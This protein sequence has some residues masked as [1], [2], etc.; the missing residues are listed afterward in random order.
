LDEFE[1]R[2][3]GFLK[4]KG[5]NLT[6]SELIDVISFLDEKKVRMIVYQFTPNDWQFNISYYQNKK[7]VEEKLIAI[8]YFHI[9]KRIMKPGYRYSISSCI[10]SQIGD[11]NRVFHHFSRLASKCRILTDFSYSRASN[12]RIIRIV[13]YIA[14]SG[15][16][17]R[18]V[19]VQKFSNY[20]F[21]NRN[22]ENIPP[23]YYRI[24]FS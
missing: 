16:N 5:R 22:S 1:S 2:F 10:E 21:N 3:P 23:W 17:L 9:A 15:K 14:I 8:I 7:D 20:S 18:K 12:N 11:I 6:K 13:D 19:D 24:I 4:R